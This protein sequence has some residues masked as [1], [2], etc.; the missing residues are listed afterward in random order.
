MFSA[1]DNTAKITSLLPSAYVEIHINCLYLET[2]QIL[3]D[4]KAKFRNSSIN[5]DVK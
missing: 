5:K 1:C 2:S 3:I 4:Q